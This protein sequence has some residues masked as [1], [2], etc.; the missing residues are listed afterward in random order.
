MQVSVVWLLL[1]LSF[2][3]VADRDVRRALSIANCQNANI[4]APFL[5]YFW[6]RMWECTFL[7]FSSDSQKTEFVRL[8][9]WVSEC[10]DEIWVDW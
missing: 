10:R 8:C 4:S 3:V 2:P 6:L 9:V 7:W 1:F 5:K